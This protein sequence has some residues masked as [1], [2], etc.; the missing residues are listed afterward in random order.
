L[1]IAIN[2]A[3]QGVYN[4]GGQS[5]SR[6]GTGNIKN[7]SICKYFGTNQISSL[8]KMGIYKKSISGIKRTYTENE[9]ELLQNGILIH[10]L[11][12]LKYR[13][14]KIFKREGSHDLIFLLEFIGGIF[15]I[16][17]QLVLEKMF[18]PKSNLTRTLVQLATNS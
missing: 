11:Q 2:S 7:G 13:K 5:Y 8:R 1:K 4:I 9:L 15:G 12:R 10:Y 17:H 6:L 14:P 16:Q 18:L 3:G